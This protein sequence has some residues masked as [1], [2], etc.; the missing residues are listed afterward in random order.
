M[1][2]RSALQCRTGRHHLEAPAA[3]GEPLQDPADPSVNA[4]EKTAS[5]RRPGKRRP[6][7]IGAQIPPEPVR[8]SAGR[9][10]S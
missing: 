3:G 6:M 10:R 9:S 5:N 4:F 2:E 7:M 1:P 8:W